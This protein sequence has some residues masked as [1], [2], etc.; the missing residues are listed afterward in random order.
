MNSPQTSFLSKSRCAHLPFDLS[1]IAWLGGSL[2]FIWGPNSGIT[3]D[4]V[5]TFGFVA[6]AAQ[7]ALYAWRLYRI[8][9][10]WQPT[11]LANGVFFTLNLVICLL[12]IHFQLGY[13]LW[14]FLIFL[15]L[16]LAVLPQRPALIIGIIASILFLPKEVP[17]NQL[18]TLNFSF[19]FDQLC[20]LAFP[21]TIGLLIHQLIDNNQARAQLIAELEAAKKML[22]TTRNRDIELATLRERE[23][24]ARDFHD[25]LGHQLT[26]LTVQLE[27]TRRLLLVDPPQAAT[28]LEE[29]QKLSRASMDELR[30]SLDNLRASGL[31]PRPLLAALQSLCADAGQRFKIILDCNL[32]ANIGPIPPAVAEVLWRVAQECLTNIGQHAQ[33]TRADASLSVLPKEILLR[34]ADNG[35]GLPAG[36]EG[37]PG[38]YGLRGLRERVEGLGG[39]FSLATPPSGGTVMEARLPIIA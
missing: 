11:V 32:P 2:W 26:T 5:S 6:A 4:A 15:G 10:G 3:W 9:R 24:L 21:W 27:A 33:A 29:M 31:G 38:H 34:I 25:T 7:L 35:V 23:R 28:L 36:A 13:Y 16:T 19:L 1:L 17:W 18:G 30:R 8:L 37:K 22:E 14:V 20:R 39:T 12:Q